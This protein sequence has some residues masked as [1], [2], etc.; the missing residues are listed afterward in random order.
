MTR[1]DEMVVAS[2]SKYVPLLLIFAVIACYSSLVKNQLHE[3]QN[4]GAASSSPTRW[5]GRRQLAT[6]VGNREAYAADPPFNPRSF[7]YVLIHYHKV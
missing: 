3:V 5:L 6:L 2:S 4:D 1:A 7:A